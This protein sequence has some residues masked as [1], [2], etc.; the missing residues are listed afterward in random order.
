MSQRH[1]FGSKFYNINLRK[2]FVKELLSFFGRAFQKKTKVNKNYLNL[3]AGSEQTYLNDQ[4]L[5]CDF[6]SLDYFNIFK[7]KKNILS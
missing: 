1:D 6:F 2:M 7:K 5:N 3:G 4:F